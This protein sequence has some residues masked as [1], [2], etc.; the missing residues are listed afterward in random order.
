MGTLSGIL[1]LYEETGTHRTP[2]AADEQALLRD[3]AVWRAMDQLAQWSTEG[4][5]PSKP[6]LDSLGVKLP[7]FLLR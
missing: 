1:R 3:S 5:V 2:A 4:H 7:H 6:E